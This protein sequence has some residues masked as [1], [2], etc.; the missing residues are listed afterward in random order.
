[1]T[2]KAQERKAYK[3]RRL[4]LLTENLGH[5]GRPPEFSTFKYVWTGQILQ[6][7]GGKS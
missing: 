2:N 7:V 1:M 6:M 4:V 3:A 5:V